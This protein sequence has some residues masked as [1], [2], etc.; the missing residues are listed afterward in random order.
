MTRA[1]AVVVMLSVLAAGAVGGAGAAE[2]KSKKR[3]WFGLQRLGA[4][5]GQVKACMQAYATNGTDYEQ[6]WPVLNG[7]SRRAARDVTTYV[8]FGADGNPDPA[9][10]HHAWEAVIRAQLETE[11][12]TNLAACAGLLEAAARK[13]TE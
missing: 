13:S 12:A 8:T 4:E 3:M 9:D 1:L 5:I 10:W 6:Y 2:F 11:A 7:L